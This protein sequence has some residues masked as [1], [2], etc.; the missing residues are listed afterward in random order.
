MQ[1]VGLSVIPT[2]VKEQTRSR[3]LVETEEVKQTAIGLTVT[4]LKAAMI[5]TPVA[6]PSLPKMSGTR[7]AQL[8]VLETLKDARLE[9]LLSY[10]TTERDGDD[11]PQNTKLSV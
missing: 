2:T 5:R 9:V 4:T 3:R 11:S 1:A 6:V 7:L 10:N 8:R